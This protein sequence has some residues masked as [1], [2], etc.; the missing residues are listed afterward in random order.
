M[1]IPN[2]SFLQSPVPHFL[3]IAIRKKMG[4]S[5]PGRIWKSCWNEDQI[6]WCPVSYHFDKLFQILNSYVFKLVNSI[7][8][9]P[10]FILTNMV[11]WESIRKRAKYSQNLFIWWNENLDQ[12][13]LS[14]IYWLFCLRPRIGNF[15]IWLGWLI[16]NGLW[17]I[18]WTSQQPTTALWNKRGPWKLVLRACKM[19]IYNTLP[20][21]SKSQPAAYFA[22]FWRYSNICLTVSCGFHRKFFEGRNV[23]A[24]FH[25]DNARSLIGTF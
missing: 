10:F 11:M 5:D 24:P 19:V 7:F 4:G 9:L 20:L 2:L 18:R 21:C 6:R 14:Y 16:E 8:K 12:R 25:F 3:Q 23:T 15:Q 1:Q 22:K 13:V 17:S